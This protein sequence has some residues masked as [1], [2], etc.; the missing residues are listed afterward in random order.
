MRDTATQIDPPPASE[1]DLSRFFKALADDTRR[2]ILALLEQ[3]ERNVTEIVQRFNLTQPTISRHLQVLR[4]ARLVSAGR[5]GQHMIYRLN[6][7]VLAQGADRFFGHFSRCR[8]AGL[9]SSSGSLS[10]LGRLAALDEG[11]HRRRLQFE[12]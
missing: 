2:S 12:R 10:Q 5:R 1:A 9:G 3:R 4:E 11:R 8:R 6:P 7:E